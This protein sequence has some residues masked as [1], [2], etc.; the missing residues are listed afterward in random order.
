MARVTCMFLQDLRLKA[1]THKLVVELPEGSTVRDL[2]NLVPEAVVREV[3]EGDRIKPP[4]DIL[5]NGRSIQLLE[6]LDTRLRD[7]DTVV[8]TQVRLF[9]L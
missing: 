1:G 7:G 3:V 9:V 2:L 5:V 6:G 4:A 8:F